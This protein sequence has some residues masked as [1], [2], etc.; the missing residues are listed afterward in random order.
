M[1]FKNS[2]ESQPA[3]P[4]SRR[5]RHRSRVEGNW[6]RPPETM[7]VLFSIFIKVLLVVVGSTGF[8]SPHLG[9]HTWFR[10]RL[11]EPIHTLNLDSSEYCPKRHCSHVQLANSLQTLPSSHYV[12]H[13]PTSELTKALFIWNQASTHDNM[14]QARA[15]FSLGFKCIEW[16]FFGTLHEE[17]LIVGVDFEER[18][19]FRQLSVTIEPCVMDTAA[20]RCLYLS[21]LFAGRSS[22]S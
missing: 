10:P 17:G 12:S 22:L 15:Q 6:T 9:S 7:N 14:L 13:I 11:P 1:Q 20:S 16:N 2:C 4:D 3:W 18:Q 8:L 21:L 19:N 5:V